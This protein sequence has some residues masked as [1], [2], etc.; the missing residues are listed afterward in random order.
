MSDKDSYITHYTY[1]DYLNWEGRWEL[2]DGHP[3]AMSPLPVPRHQEISLNIMIAL[4][5]SL[6]ESNCKHCKV[7][8]PIDYKISDDI[9]IQPDVLIV[10]GKIEKKL[11]DFAPSLVVEVLSPSTMIKDK[12]KKFSIYQQEKVKYY[13]MADLDKEAIEV[14]RL[15]NDIYQKI[16][17]TTE[18]TF[19]LDD[20][21]TINPQLHDIW[22]TD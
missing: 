1:K 3:I 4:K 7:Y 22:E 16:N 15:V 20:G 2:I 14:Y 19:D 5:A 9:I 21:C 8:P 11:L 13:L 17:F 12:N 10:C 6:R 18:Y